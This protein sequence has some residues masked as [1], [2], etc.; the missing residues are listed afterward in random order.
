MDGLTY[1]QV[2]ADLYDDTAKNLLVTEHEY[3]TED[4][5]AHDK[6]KPETYEVEAPE[7][8]QKE[9]GSRQAV[10]PPK[11]IPKYTDITT[12]SVRYNKDV[13]TRVLSIDSRFRLNLSESPTNFKYTPLVPVKNVASIRLSSVEIPNTFYTFS[14]AKG[15]IFMRVGNPALYDPNF[16]F[17]GKY[18]IKNAAARQI[19]IDDGNYIIDDNLQTHPNNLVYVI[20]NQINSTTTTSIGIQLIMNIDPVSS[21]IT[22]SNANFIPNNPLASEPFDLDFRPNSPFIDRL[23][24]WGLGYNLGFRQKFYTGQASYTAE[25]IPDT[26]GPNYLFVSL[27]PDW[28][29]VTHNSPDKQS[30][31]PFAKVVITVPKNDVIYDNG[32]NTVTKEYWLNQ[33]QDVK[34]FQIQITDPF[35]E[36]ID[37]AGGNVSLTVELKEIMNPALYEHIRSVLP[38]QQQ[39]FGAGT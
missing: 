32:S 22:I 36:V 5:P 37:L 19:G 21:K 12:Q 7:E 38:D 16:P 2:L 29:L 34:T 6:T 10:E 15:N 33:P 35:E 4:I 17:Q 9:Q 18:D 23:T 25:A 11:S 31:S 1:Q 39:E 30:M 26:I 3:E 13:N 24:D 27:Y 28:K 14:L 20:N 8:F